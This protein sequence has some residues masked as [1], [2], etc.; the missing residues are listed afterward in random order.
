[1]NI[2]RILQLALV[3]GA[4]LLWLAACDIPRPAADKSG[5]IAAELVPPPAPA[6]LTPTAT[7]TAP[8]PAVP[9][10]VITPTVPVTAS[11]ATPLPPTPTFTP[12]P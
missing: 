1:M 10:A 2:Q 3:W 12:V 6:G 9:T 5:D 4:V 8:I 11:A 7:I